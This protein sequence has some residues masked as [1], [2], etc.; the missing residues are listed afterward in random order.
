VR[1]SRA[2]KDGKTVVIFTSRRRRAGHDA[3]E[4]LQLGRQISSQLVEIVD[5]IDV[6]PRFFVA[7]GGITSSDIA[8][9]SLD[10]RRAVVRGQI[11][12]GI[13]VWQLG[14]ESRFPGMNY[15]VFPGNVGEADALQQLVQKL[16][17][18]CEPILR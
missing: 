1:A 13:P 6:E 17:T 15:I 2:L 5:Q 16:N 14:A 18:A 7:K 10:V 3:K 4:T 11:L 12:P 9:R 8:T